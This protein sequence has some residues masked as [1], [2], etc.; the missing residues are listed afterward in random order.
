MYGDD[1]MRSLP[2]ETPARSLFWV[3]CLIL[4]SCLL[5]LTPGTCL[6]TN[7]ALGDDEEVQE[8]EPFAEHRVVVADPLESWN[9]AM[10]TF[11]DR[12]YFWFAKPVAQ[13]YGSVLPEG[14]RTCIRNGY[15][16]INM[17][18]RFVNNVLQGKIRRAGVEI[19]RFLINSTIGFCGFFEIAAR[20]FNL[21]PYDEDTGQT[22][23]FYGMPEVLYITWPFLGPSTLRDS[24]GLAGDCFENPLHYYTPIYTSVAI[25]GGGKLNDLSLRI[26]EYE[27]FKKSAVDP[28]ISMRDAYIQ[29]RAER[30]RK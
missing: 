14:L 25:R 30:I 28:Y 12:F 17:P 6:G 4:F 7:T 15:A 21:Q 2:N 19:A 13:A 27:D 29:H 18:V 5:A 26:G 23:G 22:L 1:N 16:N 20:D 11:N 10:F 3:G 24:L 9:R 8:R